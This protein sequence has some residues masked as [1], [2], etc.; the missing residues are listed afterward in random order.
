ML[1]ILRVSP[2]CYKYGAVCVI[3]IE[4]VV[5]VLEM[6]VFLLYVWGGSVVHMVSVCRRYGGHCVVSIVDIGVS[7]L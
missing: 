1:K 6:G 7:V 3:E 4:G 2:L 5:Y